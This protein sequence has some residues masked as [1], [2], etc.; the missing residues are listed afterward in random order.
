MSKRPAIDGPLACLPGNFQ[1]KRSRL[2]ITVEDSPMH[3]ESPSVSDDELLAPQTPLRPTNPLSSE[4]SPPDSQSRPTESSTSANTTAKMP[5]SATVNANGKRKWA[6][7][8]NDS[9]GQGPASAQDGSS[10]MVM[11]RDAGSGYTWTREEDAPGYAWNNHK[12]K[13][14]ASREFSRFVDK[15]RMIKGEFCQ[16]R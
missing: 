3:D 7:N 12:A 5:P 2:T 16:S 4:L 13:E 10:A 14:E 1:S 8:G 15:D 9:V 6:T 11:G